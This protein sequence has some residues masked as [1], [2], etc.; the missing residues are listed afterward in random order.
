[1]TSLDVI[2]DFWAYQ[3]S[4]KADANPQLDN[5]AYATTK[6]TGSVTVRCDELC[7]LWHG[8]MYN[9]GTVVPKATF[10]GWAKATERATAANTKNLP[11]FCLDLRPRRQ[12]RRRW[13]LSR[14]RRPVQQCR[15]LRCHSAKPTSSG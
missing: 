8:A 10:Y 5:V 3:L 4:I 1:M 9:Y 2:H 15:G 12:R 7:G 6:Q 14:Q 11:P 13:V